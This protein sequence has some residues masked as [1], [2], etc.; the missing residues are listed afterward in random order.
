MVKALHIFRSVKH[1]PMGKRFGER[2]SMSLEVGQSVVI[3]NQMSF[4]API[5][6]IKATTMMKIHMYPV[7]L[8]QI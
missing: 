4:T 3:L 7:K 1:A 6:I 2:E 5:A 8:N